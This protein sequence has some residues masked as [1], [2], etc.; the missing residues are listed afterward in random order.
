MRVAVNTPQVGAGVPRIV[1]Q[2]N[3]MNLEYLRKR[4]ADRHGRQIVFTAGVVNQAGKLGL[5][6]DDGVR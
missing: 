3:D 5:A 2:I 1:M 4:F 6:R